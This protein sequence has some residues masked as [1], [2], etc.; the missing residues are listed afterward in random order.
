MKVDPKIN[1]NHKDMMKIKLLK[2]FPYVLSGVE[3]EINIRP[4]EAGNLRSS[5]HNKGNLCILRLYD[6]N[7]V[8]EIHF[9]H[10]QGHD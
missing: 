2:Y 6:L 8:S 10:I 4:L 5:L 9:L 1:Q 7:L 3:I